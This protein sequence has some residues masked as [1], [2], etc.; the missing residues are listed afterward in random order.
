MLLII[1]ALNNRMYFDANAPLCSLAQQSVPFL[2][3][4]KPIW[5]RTWPALS[6]RKGLL[7]CLSN[8]SESPPHTPP[9]D[10][11]GGCL[12]TTGP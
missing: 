6:P 11:R 2:L 7:R 10:P 4:N 1:M 9:S 8:T 5:S 12:Q 3:L